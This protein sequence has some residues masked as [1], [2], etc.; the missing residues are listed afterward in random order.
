MHLNEQSIA[1]I[2]AEFS[3]T[4]EAI[5]FEISDEMTE[6][7]LRARASAFA[8]A[9]ANAQA[10]ESDAGDEDIADEVHND[11]NDEAADAAENSE[12]DETFS[13]T[14]TDA[15][16]PMTFAATYNE[17]YDAL[18]HAVRALSDE[19][20]EV[21]FY[22]MDFDDTYV[23][24]SRDSFGQGEYDCQR[25]RFHY[26]FDES[27]KDA[28]ITG[29]FEELFLMWLTSEERDALERRRDLLDELMAY[30]N[31]NE[32][33]SYVDSINEIFAAFCDLDGIDEFVQYQKDVM[34]QVDDADNRP[35]IE[36]VTEHCYSI[37]GKQVKTFNKKLESVKPARVAVEKP[38]ATQANPKY[39]SLFEKF[40][41]K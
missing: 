5:D 20:N 27:T 1:E 29:D 4:P 37:R 23:Y 2:L 24:V 36:S 40:G 32:K 38:A 30:R 17:R 9:Q 18:A 41:K 11:A 31:E 39:A 21:Y 34:A 22:L 10:Q 16:Q 33:K 13:V 12:T 14:N 35:S 25:G 15:D 8:A 3:L 7:D 26:A 28:T 19:A 6:D